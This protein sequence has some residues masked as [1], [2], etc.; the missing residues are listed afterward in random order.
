ER[1]AGG[2]A[3]RVRPR[4]AD[5]RG[6]RPL[7]GPGGERSERQEN[8]QPPAPA[9]GAARVRRVPRLLL[10]LEAPGR[11]CVQ[12]AR[13]GAESPPPRASPLREHTHPRLD[14]KSTRLNSSHV[15]ISY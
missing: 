2:T 8:L 5:A 13:P 4:A 14:R 15:A 9:G 3:A 12:R 10:R 1:G 11:P 7:G 6:P